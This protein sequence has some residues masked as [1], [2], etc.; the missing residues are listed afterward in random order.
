MI[1]LFRKQKEALRDSVKRI[2]I[3]DGAVRSG[4]SFVSILRFS[5]FMLQRDA[6]EKFFVCGVTNSSIDR[7]VVMPLKDFYGKHFHYARSRSTGNFFGRK[8]ILFGNG[9]EDSLRGSEFS[10]GYFDEIVLCKESFYKMALSRLSIEGA[11]LHGSTNPANPKH[12]FKKGYIDRRSELNMYYQHYVLDDNIFL[13]ESYRRDIKNEYTGLWY[14]RFINGE[15]VSGDG[16]IYDFFDD[17]PKEGY[18]LNAVPCKGDRYYIS[19]DYGTQN[20]TVFLLFGLLITPKVVKGKNLKAW[21]EDEYYY[22][23]K[24]SMKQKTDNEYADDMDEFVRKSKRRISGVIV[25]PSAASFKAELKKRG[26]IVIDA[27]NSVLDGLREQSKALATFLY[28]IVKK[29]CNTIDE[30]F[31]Y[32]WDKKKCD[33]GEDAPKKEFDHTKD[34]ERYFIKTILCKTGLDYSKLTTA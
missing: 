32:E 1:N 18:V 8:V 10:G 16:A 11:Q 22:S 5:E 3:L 14:R 2:N 4:K 28:R 12:W 26:Y 29:C 7:N 20:P 6:G 9:S 25:D 21:C 17:N 23:G 33:R 13:P 15:W 34:A 30:Y 24:E 19:V 31:A 27:D